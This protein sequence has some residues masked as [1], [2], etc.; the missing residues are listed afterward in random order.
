MRG[1]RER[2]RKVSAARKKEKIRRRLGLVESEREK[3]EMK[4][5]EKSVRERREK[6]REGENFWEEGI[7]KHLLS[8]KF[9]MISCNLLV[10]NLLRRKKREREE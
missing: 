10:C 7:I 2:I 5:M 4:R 6:E 8:L 9:T 1:N 3:I